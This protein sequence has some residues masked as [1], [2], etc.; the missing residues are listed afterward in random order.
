MKDCTSIVGTKLEILFGAYED[1]ILKASISPSSWFWISALRFHEIYDHSNALWDNNRKE[2]EGGSVQRVLLPSS[3]TQGII[4]LYPT[5]NS[6]WFVS[7]LGS[8]WKSLQIDLIPKNPIATQLI[9]HIIYVSYLNKH[10]CFQKCICHLNALLFPTLSFPIL[11][12]PFE[13]IIVLDLQHKI[14]CWTFCLEPFT[15]IVIKLEPWCW[16]PK[17]KL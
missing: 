14:K 13:Y 16:H 11:H 4:F 5:W 2:V 3:F 10:C 12:L 17:S 7:I 8:I 15:S 9:M 1:N 6:F